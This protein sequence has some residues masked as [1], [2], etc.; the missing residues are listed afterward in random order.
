MIINSWSKNIKKQWKND[1]VKPN[2]PT[3]FMTRDTI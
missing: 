3:E 2:K 1:Q